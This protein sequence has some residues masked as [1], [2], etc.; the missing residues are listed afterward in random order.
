MA[1]FVAVYGT[2]C[3]Y[4]TAWQP[5]LIM[6]QAYQ[7]DTCFISPRT[8]IL[9]GC[10]PS[11]HHHH[12]PAQQQRAAS[13][14]RNGRFSDFTII[15]SITWNLQRDSLIS[16]SRLTSP[17]IA[18]SVADHDDMTAYLNWR[19][20]HTLR[21]TTESKTV[22]DSKHV[23]F[24]CDMLP[25]NCCLFPACMWLDFVRWWERWSGRGG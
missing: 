13:T 25:G 22:R 10:L 21:E 8:D 23:R 5:S 6:F 12:S 18:L 16:P 17:L 7:K 20:P 3:M 1:R 11:L 14:A 15:S 2:C 9:Y 24:G 4:T 19:T